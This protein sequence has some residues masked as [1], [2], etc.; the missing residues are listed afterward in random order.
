MF[1]LDPQSIG[2][3]AK[4]SGQ[5]VHLPTLG[6]SALRG[7]FGFA[8]VSLG[9][10][11]PWVFVGRWFY[12]N[13]GEVG[14][15]AV[16][17]LVFI[18]LSG[19]L[20]HRLIIGSSSLL[21]FYQLFSLAFVGYAVAWTFGWMVVRGVTGSMVGALADMAV[22]S[23]ILVMDWVSARASASRF[24]FVRPKGATFFNLRNNELRML[25]RP[26]GRVPETGLDSKARSVHVA[27]CRE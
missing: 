6:E 21:R 11:A 16:C 4:A 3:R 25:K 12:R 13:T 15:Y 22:M 10:F 20:L 18:G 17:A 8:L 9:G 26:E 7:M 5:P 23:G 2:D 19:V 27:Y 1:G 14:L 24:I